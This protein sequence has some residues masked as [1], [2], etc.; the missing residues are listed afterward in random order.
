LTAASWPI[1]TSAGDGPRFVFPWCFSWVDNE[2]SDHYCTIVKRKNSVRVNER[3]TPITNQFETLNYCRWYLCVYD[4]YIA[5]YLCT[6][7]IL[8]SCC[9]CCPTLPTSI[10]NN[11]ICTSYVYIVPITYKHF[12]YTFGNNEIRAPV[13]SK[14]GEHHNFLDTYRMGTSL[15]GCKALSICTNVSGYRLMGWSV[16]WSFRGSVITCTEILKT[17]EIVAADLACLLKNL[18]GT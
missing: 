15:R 18:A 7:L 6:F 17:K 8:Q 14:S 16:I 11:I 13:H 3:H 10:N 2:L 12:R 4:T 1:L 9:N 5:T